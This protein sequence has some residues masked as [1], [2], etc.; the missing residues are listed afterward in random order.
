MFASNMCV[1]QATASWFSFAALSWGSLGVVYGDLGTSPLYLWPSVFYQTPETEDIVGALSLVLWTL[2]L[3]VVVK[4][5][6]SAPSSPRPV[7]SCK[8]ASR[9]AAVPFVQGV[10]VVPRSCMHAPAMSFQPAGSSTRFRFAMETSPP[11]IDTPASCLCAGHCP[12]CKRPWRGRHICGEG[13]C[14][15]RLLS[16]APA[17]RQHAENHRRERPQDTNSPCKMGKPL[18]VAR[19]LGLV[20]AALAALAGRALCA[21]VLAAVPPRRDQPCG[22]R[23]G[24]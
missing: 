9:L 3:I 14:S 11:M 2:T 24:G 13:C 7:V 17:S 19:L 10:C 6:V 16:T 20:C 1:L 23:D 22:R 12:E 15:A 21:G 18:C 4:Y 8:P 5:V